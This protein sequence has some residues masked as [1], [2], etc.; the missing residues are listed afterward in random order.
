MGMFTDSAGR[1]WTIV[2]DVTAIKRVRSALGVNL[3]DVIG[4]ELL[5]RLTNDP[6]LL[7]DILYCLVKP[8]ADSRK[9]TDEDFG[10]AI[11]GDVIHNATR[12]FLESL[13]DFFPSA[14]REI[15]LKILAKTTEIEQ[16]VLKQ[17]MAKLDNITI[18]Q[19]LQAV[20]AGGSFGN[21]QESSG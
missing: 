4:G 6:V 1:A 9:L 17:A 15:L 3:L 7:C 20:T 13:A 5:N 12:A 19:I 18:D 11:N 10:R 8:E 14:Q 16:T 2:I 21:S